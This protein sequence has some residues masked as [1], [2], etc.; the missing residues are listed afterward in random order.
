MDPRD[1]IDLGREAIMTALLVSAPVLLTGMVVGL[2]I[3]L[4]QALTQIQE[5]TVAF[6]PKIVAMVVVLAL[7][8][9]VMPTYSPYNQVLLLPGIL[10]LARDGPALW[11]RSRGNRVLLAV[12]LVL[13]TWPYL[14]AGTLAL[15]SFVLPPATVEKAWAVPGWTI[16]TLPIGVAALMLLYAYRQSFASPV[17]E[18]Q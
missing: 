14:S 18:S 1:I 10:S 4:L 13:L 15:L 3:G 16:L 2:V 17:V 9:L 8:L 7:T 11:R 6:V 12:N 5:Q